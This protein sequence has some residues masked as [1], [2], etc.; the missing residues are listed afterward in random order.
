M[1]LKI[2]EIKEWLIKNAKW[3]ILFVSI[4]AFLALVEDVWDKDIDKLDV[5]GYKI[6]STTLISDFMTPVAKF[7]TNLG[8]A[9]FLI[10]LA[11]LSVLLIKNK[12]I[13]ISVCSNLVVA[14]V[15]NFLLKNILQ[16][17]RP[18]EFRIIDEN[19][20]SFPSGH[21]MVSM[22][23]YGFIIYLIYKYV[24]KDNIKW[25]LI[26]FLGALILFIGVS[27]IYLGVHY[28]SDVLGGFLISISYLIIYTSIVKKVIK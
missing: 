22:A 25:P 20:Y 11:M 24:K 15:L 26:I 17:P 5:I 10:L 4:I 6:I 27:R 13:G 28:T 12:K 23:F 2:G 19:G 14:A 21:S 7:I 9:T 8:S 3:I 16:R 18:T 1:Q